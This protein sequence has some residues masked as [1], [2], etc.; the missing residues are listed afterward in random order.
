MKS[1]LRFQLP[2]RHIAPVPFFNA[3]PPLPLSQTPISDKPHCGMLSQQ[4]D[5]ASE[6]FSRGGPG[7]SGASVMAMKRA[8]PLP[9]MEDG[10]F[11]RGQRG[12]DSEHCGDG[13]ASGCD[14]APFLR[15]IIHGPRLPHIVSNAPAIAS[16]ACC[17]ARGPSTSRWWWLWWG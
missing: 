14:C 13:R 9:N 16:W 5:G 3:T 15:C 2:K 7:S 11:G 4:G 1:A 12:Q 10:C 8:S 17:R 6:A